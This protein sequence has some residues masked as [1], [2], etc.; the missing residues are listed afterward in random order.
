MST[1]HFKVKGKLDGAGGM[2][3][4]TLSI[5]RETGYVTVRPKGCRSTYAIPIGEL[6]TLVCQRNLPTGRKPV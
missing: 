3:E 2:H 5:D 1:A 4:G 6:A